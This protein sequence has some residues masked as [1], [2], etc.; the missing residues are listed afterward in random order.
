MPSYEIHTPF[1]PG[2]TE[3]HPRRR[4]LIDVPLIGPWLD[5]ALS[6][7]R[8]QADVDARL[9]NHD[10]RLSTI[11]GDMLIMTT[12]FDEQETRGAQLVALIQAEFASLRQQ[13]ADEQA[14]DQAQVDAAVTDAR[15]ADAERLGK[16]LDTLAQVVPGTPPVVETPAP[17]EPAELPAE[18]TPGDQGP[19]TSDDVIA[20]PEVL[21][22]EAS[23]DAANP[24]GTP[25]DGSGVTDPNDAGGPTVP[26]SS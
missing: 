5:Y 14:D 23:A 7:W 24:A 10:H 12:S 18:V 1:P 22:P 8:R 2:G 26:P 13:L 17:G 4:R 19:V 9:L 3:P 6:P 16:L 25:T 20:D 15:N 21:A 11:E